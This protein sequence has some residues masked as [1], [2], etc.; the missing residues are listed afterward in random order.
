MRYLPLGGQDGPGAIW[1]LILVSCLAVLV[2]VG[3]VSLTV[4]AKL[5]PAGISTTVA[6]LLLLAAWGL[7]VRFLLLD[8]WGRR[9]WLGVQVLFLVLILAAPKVGMVLGLVGSGFFL[10][11]RRYR[12]W[13]L[14]TARQRAL[15]FGLSLVMLPALIL[16]R[17]FWDVDAGGV[18]LD[19]LRCLGGWSL[20]NLIGFWAWSLVHLVLRM[21]LHFMRLRPKL[22]VN[23]ILIGFIP[24]VL[25][26]ALGV[27]ILYTGLGGSR[28]VRA[29]DTLE[30]WR[31]MT[32][33]GS[34]LAGA[35]FDTTFVWP[36]A[37]GSK[38]G[39]LRDAHRIPAPTVLPDLA[40]DLAGVMPVARDTAGLAAVASDTT[41]WFVLDGGIWLV[42][43]QGLGTDHPRAKGWKLGVRPLRRLSGILGA[44]IEISSIDARAEGKSLVLSAPSEQDRKLFP[45]LKVSA[46]DITPDSPFWDRPMFFGGTLFRVWKIQDRVLD[47]DMVFINLKVGWPEIS[48]DFFKGES[49]INI[50]VVVVLGLLVFLFLVLE[51]FAVFFGVRITEGIVS[52]VHALRDGMRAVAAG[53]LETRVRVPNEDEFGDLAAGFN[54][55]TASLKQGREVALA[56]DRLQQELATARAIQ[57]RLL[58]GQVPH[59]DGFE[60]A[61]TSI[62]SRE[63]GGDYYD[64][65][66]QG[67]DLVG[68][69]IGD[70]SGKGMPAALLMSNLQASLHGQVLHPGT[71]ASVVASVNELLV[72]STDAHMFATFFYGLLNTTTGE[73]TC[74]NAGHNPPLVV[75]R[76][77]TIEELSRGGLLL[78]MLEEQVYQQDTVTLQP[79][80]VI[81]MYTDGITEAVGPGVEEDDPEAMFGEEALRRVVLENRHLPAAGI[82]E[83]ILAAVSAHTAGV[84][85]SD[86]ITLVVIR[87]R[88]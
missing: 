85:Q 68:I 87:R 37:G 25:I 52:A 55:M 23:A 7:V 2:A 56:N 43:W 15:G 6:G 27:V 31:A 51:L 49:N 72:R 26:S 12:P 9:W 39:T 75:H 57:V 30:S 36:A 32:A 79:G 10:T 53:D 50:A 35:V 47:S 63:I 14:V 82:Q 40:R 44:A 77:G 41:D 19:R 62:P 3:T 45:G 34:D 59:L 46:R 60:V 78:G 81:V 11:F 42:R 61:G 86:D 33:E 64:F 84:P 8:T 16:A 66:A 69:A 29:R 80:D 65:L 1:R 17:R 54:D 48:G 38:P 20:G 70:V 21:R 88:D 58:P 22:A 71:V 67:E 83:A 76:D 13:R 28:A 18:F 24:L 74:T 5:M 4:D 73:F